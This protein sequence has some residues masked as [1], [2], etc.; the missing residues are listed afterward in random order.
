MVAP[1]LSAGAVNVTV[2]VVAPVCVAVPIV[3]ALGTVT[4]VTDALETLFALVPAM[5]YAFATK[6]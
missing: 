5:L 1:P 4:G 6:V 3:G 2:A